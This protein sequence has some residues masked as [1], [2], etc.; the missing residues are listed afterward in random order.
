M[1]RD[2]LS[3]VGER[4]V[5]IGVTGH[6]QLDAPDDVAR[7]V[8]RTID[9]LVA[10]FGADTSLVVVSSLAEGADR[11]VA[12]R[13]L[14]RPGATLEVILPLTAEDYAR[15][16]DSSASLDAFQALLDRASHIRVVPTDAAGPREQAYEAA[17]LALLD[18]TDVVLALWDGEE[19]RGRGGTAEMV[20]A[21]RERGRRVVVIPVTRPTAEGETGAPTP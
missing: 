15:D 12:E 10:A 18:R 6:R 2:K 21:A 5:R 9:D 11:L 16:F 19:S 8:D 3:T 1:R 13:V 20:Q 14:D 7:V 17:G 4:I